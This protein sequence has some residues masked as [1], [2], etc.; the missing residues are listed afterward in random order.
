MALGPKDRLIMVGSFAPDEVVPGGGH[1]ETA[2]ASG[3]LVGGGIAFALGW[4]PDFYMGIFSHPTGDPEEDR[5]L[6]APVIGPWV[7][8]ATRPSCQ[9]VPGADQAGVDSCLD[10]KVARWAIIVSGILQTAGAVV[11]VLGLPAHA[12]LV[13]DGRPR[14]SIVPV[15]VP[16]GG[17]A[18]AVGAF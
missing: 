11:F 17:G 18:A 14:A 12:E 7:D 2:R 4:L 10:D 15:P 16:G 9:P 3:M 1:V 8:L 13:D 5:W 6:I